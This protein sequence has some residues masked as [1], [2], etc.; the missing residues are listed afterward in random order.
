MA[1]ELGVHPTVQR[2]N[3][4]LGMTFAVQHQRLPMPTDIAD[5]L[6][7][8]MVMHQSLGVVHPIQREVIATFRHHEFVADVTRCLWKQQLLFECVNRR[9][10]ISGDRKLR[11]RWPF[12]GR[13]CS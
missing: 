6:N 8:M 12:E 2:A 9:V 13:D 10:N 4:V 3:D 11:D 7:T 5:Q 1:I